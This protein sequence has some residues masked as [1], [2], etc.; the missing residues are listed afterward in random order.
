[1]KRFIN[2]LKIIDNAGNFIYFGDCMAKSS[3]IF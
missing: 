1:M 2:F 3:D